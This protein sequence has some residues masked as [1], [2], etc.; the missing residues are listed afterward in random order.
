[1]VDAAIQGMLLPLLSLSAAD[2]YANGE[3]N[4]VWRTILGKNEMFKAGAHT[5]CLLDFLEHGLKAVE[6]FVPL[7]VRRQRNIV[8]HI[9]PSQAD[10][11][12]HC[13]KPLALG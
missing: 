11:K 13:C 6:P 5:S 9:V 8:M 3:P 2:A 12:F 10:A 1:M 4:A 7:L